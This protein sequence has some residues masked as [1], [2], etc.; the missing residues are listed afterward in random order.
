MFYTT[1][2]VLLTTKQVGII[3]KIEFSKAV[4]DENV[5]TLVIY[6]TSFNLNSIPIYLG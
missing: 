4:L 3:D 5:K 6:I 1:T 2:K